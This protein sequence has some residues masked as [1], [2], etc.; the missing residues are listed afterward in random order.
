VIESPRDLAGFRVL[1]AD[2]AGLRTSQDPI[3]IEGVR[4]AQQ[5]AESAALRVWVVDGAAD[6]GAWREVANVV[7]AGDVCVINKQDLKRGSAAGAARAWAAAHGLECVDLSLKNGAGLAGLEAR[8]TE[9]VTAALSGAEFPAATRER[10]R[11]DLSA[12][13]AHLGRALLALSGPVEVELAAEDV[14]LA[15]RCLAKI[16]GRIDPEDVLDRVFAR[17]CIGK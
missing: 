15:A 2:T 17:F 14:R 7:R 10:H 3:E 6:D 4:R 5:R 12:A 1:L 9:R 16:G 11:Q 13:R 8:L